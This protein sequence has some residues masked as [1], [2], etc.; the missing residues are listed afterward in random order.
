MIGKEYTDSKKNQ[1]KILKW[2]I[3][4]DIKNLIVKLNRRQHL[5]SHINLDIIKQN[6]VTRHYGP[7][8]KQYVCKKFET[9][10]D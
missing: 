8:A 9:E 5:N 7:P 1:M 2:K 4:I 3:I 10:S 6:T